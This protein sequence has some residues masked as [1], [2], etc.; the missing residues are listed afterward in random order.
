M[1]TKDELERATRTGEIAREAARSWEHGR[2]SALQGDRRT[3]RR[4]GLRLI[5]GAGSKTPWYV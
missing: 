4:L 1:N 3:A 5:E 2:E